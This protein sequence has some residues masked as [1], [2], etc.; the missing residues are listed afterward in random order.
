MRLANLTLTALAALSL[1]ACNNPRQGV[2]GI[3]TPFPAAAAQTVGGPAAASSADPSGPVDDC[4]HRWAYSLAGASDPADAVAQAAVS[5]CTAALSR[6]NQQGMAPAAGPGADTADAVSLVTG[7]PVTAFQAHHEFAQ[8]RALFY[9]VQA[10]AGHCAPPPA[11]KGGPA[12]SYPN[13]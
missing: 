5:A 7:Q 9:V 1:G 4:L 2:K 11:A 3:C 8:G 13:V 6:W 10:R 12:S